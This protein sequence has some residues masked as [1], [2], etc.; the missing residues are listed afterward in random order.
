MTGP[1]SDSYLQPE[2][3]VRPK[4]KLKTEENLRE[5][6]LKEISELFL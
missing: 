3:F 5:K 6:L 4:K 1:S 2:T